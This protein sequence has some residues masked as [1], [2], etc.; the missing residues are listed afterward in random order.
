MAKGPYT[1]EFDFR[2]KRFTDATKGLQHFADVLKT[3]YEKVGPVLKR[4]LELWL[5]GVSA[6]MVKDHSGSWPAGT[7]GKTLSK[8]SGAALQSIKDSI[9]VEGT[10]IATTQGRI[11]G[12]S[13][14]RTQEFGATI[15]PKRAQYLTVPL[16]AALDSRG[17]PLKSGARQWENTFVKKGKSGHLLIFQKRGR[18][19]V[20]LYLL[21]KEV[22]IP[23]RLGMRTTLEVGKKA[24]VDMTVRDMLKTLRGH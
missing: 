12:I 20:P 3:N 10:N 22:K 8:R 21:V 2:G 24:F 14:L 6:R 15:R 5:N 17:V 7:T 9:R 16:K 18:T 11:G 4:D 1:V 23:P 13:Y 19:I